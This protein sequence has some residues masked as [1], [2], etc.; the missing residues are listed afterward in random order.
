MKFLSL[1]AVTAFFAT[2]QGA[3][4][5]PAEST[6]SNTWVPLDVLP[7]LPPGVTFETTVDKRDELAKRSD[8]K[9]TVYQDNRFGG[10]REDLATDVQKC[11]E[12]GNHWSDVI[13]SLKVPKGYGCSFY[14]DG[15]CTG[16]TFNV[17]GPD[18]VPHVKHFGKQFNDKI[19]SYLCYRR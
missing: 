5:E 10:R 13:T 4:V 12:L 14:T 6:A 9:L 7:E 17:A 2:I 16:D 3:P 19:S 18:A 15:R 11:Y 8:L 1:V